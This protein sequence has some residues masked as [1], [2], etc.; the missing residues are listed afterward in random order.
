MFTGIAWAIEESGSYDSQLPGKDGTL[1]IG[2][3]KKLVHVQ[4]KPQERAPRLMNIANVVDL[5][6]GVIL[7]TIGL[8]A[9][10]YPGMFPHLPP[11]FVLPIIISG[12]VYTAI[13][14]PT[15]CRALIK[16]IVDLTKSPYCCC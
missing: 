16:P 3:E 13:N 5:F 8:L 9:L 1:L 11:S 6:A 10:Q 14:T 2:N 4:S 12:I 7:L 15:G